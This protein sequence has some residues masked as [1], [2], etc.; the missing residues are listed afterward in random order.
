MQ[1]SKEEIMSQEKKKKTVTVG[2]RGGFK[3]LKETELIKI[4]AL[5]HIFDEHP[6]WHRNCGWSGQE[7]QLYSNPSLKGPDK[8]PH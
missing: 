4:Q 5:S 8:D 2:M 7:R 3:G 6:L 1:W